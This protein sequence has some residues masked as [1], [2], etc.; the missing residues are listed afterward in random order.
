[1]KDKDVQFETTEKR[2]STEKVDRYSLQML[3]VMKRMAEKQF[4]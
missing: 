2:K 3:C 4:L 1:M